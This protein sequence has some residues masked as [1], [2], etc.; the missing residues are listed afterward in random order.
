MGG[1][2]RASLILR[3]QSPYNKELEKGF[4]LDMTVVNAYLLY[5][6]THPNKR[7]WLTHTQFRITLAKELLES[8]GILVDQNSPQQEPGRHPTPHN[9]AARLQERHFPSA[10][11]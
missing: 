5:T 8:A 6:D 9:P 7:G 10:I 4:I 2:D 11:G 3:L 1:V